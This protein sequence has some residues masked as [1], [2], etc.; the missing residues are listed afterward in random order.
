MGARLPVGNV[1]R[2]S[3]GGTSYSIVG[4]AAPGDIY[5]VI[6]Q[7]TNG[8]YEIVLD[9]GTTGFVSGNLTQFT[10]GSGGTVQTVG[11]VSQIRATIPVYY[12]SEAGQNLY[13]DYVTLAY[14]GNKLAEYPDWVVWS[15]AKNRSGPSPVHLEFR[16]DFAHFRFDPHGRHLSERL[17]DER[18]T[19]DAG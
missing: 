10:P 8:W 3:G 15:I 19:G 6:S 18:F 7:T 14:G 16:K 13:T 2:R 1:P 12:R 11:D 17:A 5:Q 9:N 4:M